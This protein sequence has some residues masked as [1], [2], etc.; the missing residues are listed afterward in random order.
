MKLLGQT[1]V[2]D[3]YKYAIT[4]LIEASKDLEVF[5]LTVDHI[6][7]SYM[8]PNENSL[9]SFIEHM[10]DVNKADI[11]YPIILSPCNVILDG[12]HRVAKAIVTGQLKIK[13]VRFKEM[14]IRYGE[15]IGGE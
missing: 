3:D 5:E 13:A 10:K 15:Y 12:K 2:F 1:Q 4:D 11:S 6:N 8:A 9:A 7:L 14:P